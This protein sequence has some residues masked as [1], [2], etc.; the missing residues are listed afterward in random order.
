MVIV[1]L[2]SE[3]NKWKIR[4]KKK[5]LKETEIWIEENRMFRGRKIEWK[6]RK[7]AQEV[8]KKGKKV[9][10]AKERIWIE[11]RLFYWLDEI[12]VVRNGKERRRS[13]EERR[14]KTAAKKGEGIKG[15]GIAEGRRR[16]GKEKGGRRE[17]KREKDKK[18]VRKRGRRRKQKGEGRI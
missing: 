10:V 3:K 8:G 9:K 17:E 15:K 2:R 11:D 13:G 5:R 6:I 16:G 7:I 12:M 14:K 1:K 4:D 18:R